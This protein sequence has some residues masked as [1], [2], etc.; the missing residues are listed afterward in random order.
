LIVNGTW[1]LHQIDTSSGKQTIWATADDSKQASYVDGKLQVCSRSDACAKSTHWL[2]PAGPAYAASTVPVPSAVPSDVL[3]QLNAYSTGCTDVAG[4]CNAVAVIANVA[5]GY[6]KWGGFQEPNWFLALAEVPGVTV[7]HLTD[8]TGQHD[9]AF[10]FPFT[11]GVTEILF[12]AGTHQLV[13]YV[14]NGVQTVL[15]KAAIAPGPGL[16]PPA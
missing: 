3:T 8:V 7:Q 14:R 1:I 10:R 13:G 12:N 4:D 5:T 15:T 2:M 11:D 16:F 6:A 9:V